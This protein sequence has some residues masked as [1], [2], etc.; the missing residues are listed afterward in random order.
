[1]YVVYQYMLYKILPP[2]LSLSLSLSDKPPTAG[3]DLCCLSY[4][5]HTC[6]GDLITQVLF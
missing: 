3:P 6:K 2:P 1:M 4:V 5:S